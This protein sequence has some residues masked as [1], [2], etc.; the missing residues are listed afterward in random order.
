LRFRADRAGSQ[1]AAPKK[2]A[3]SI[4]LEAL[5]KAGFG[6][7]SKLVVVVSAAGVV[8]LATGSA[9]AAPVVKTKLTHINAAEQSGN[10]SGYGTN[11]TETGLTGLYKSV[12][13]EWVIPSVSAETAGQAEDTSTWIGI[14][15]NTL[16]ALIPEGDPTLIQTGTEQDVA[17]DGSTTYDAWWEIL[18]EPETEVTSMAV[19]PGDLM[20]ATITEGTIPEDWTI[21]IADLTKGATGNESFTTTTVYPSLMDTAEWVHEAPTLIAVNGG[22]ATLA[23]S[24]PVRFTGAA[25]NGSAINL[26]T[27]DQIQMTDSTGTTV[28]AQPSAPD[29]TGSGFQVCTYS[30]TTC[31]TP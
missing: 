2:K 5:V 28:I 7:R 9:T 17:A 3:N 19:S 21:T 13:G 4:V 11:I 22:I 24:A 20:K 1:S 29:S 10:W 26:N 25:L 8:A 23:K 30:G 12:S 16:N 15:G 27:A 18:P 14:G 31:P 6:L